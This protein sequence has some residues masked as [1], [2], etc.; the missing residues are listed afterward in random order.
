MKRRSVWISAAAAGGLLAGGGA[1]LWRARD[2]AVD[3]WALTFEAVPPSA[4][5]VRL[6]RG[7]PLL[8]NFWATW[9]APCVT[10]MPLLD[11]FASEQATTWRVLALA[12]DQPA[13]VA[14]FIRA[15]ALRL[16]VALAGLAGIEL[17]RGLG[18]PT[19]AL[20]FTC[21]FDADGD[22]AA[23]HLGIVDAL[24]LRRWVE[25]VK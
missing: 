22:M 12:V 15:H 18:N 2:P 3:P 10:E 11:R 17:S 13:A 14:S 8:V 25:T 20:P 5:P 23:R 9:C 16:P 7:R 1:A 21:V 19:G 24:A 6:V 4:E